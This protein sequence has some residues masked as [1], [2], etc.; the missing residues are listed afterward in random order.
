MK[1][2]QDGKIRT[3][4]PEKERGYTFWKDDLGFLWLCDRSLFVIP[5]M[6]IPNSEVEQA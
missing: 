5:I 3:L 2:K 1:I 4:K 6:R